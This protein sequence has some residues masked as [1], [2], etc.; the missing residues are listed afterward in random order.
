MSVELRYLLTRLSA[1][2]FDSLCVLVD[3]VLELPALEAVSE[4]AS[5]SEGHLSTWT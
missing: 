3:P 1:L 2:D 5:S 4:C